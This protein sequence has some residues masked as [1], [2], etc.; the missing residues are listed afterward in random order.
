MSVSNLHWVTLPIGV[1]LSAC[2][3]DAGVL[4][5]PEEPPS[6]PAA[7]AV[8]TGDNQEGKAG[9]H[10]GEPFVIRVTDTHGD[11]VG[12]VGVTWSVTSGDGDFSAPGGWSPR[13][14]TITN[15]DGMAQVFFR[16]KVLGTNTAAARIEG[17]QG[18]PV[19]FTTHATAL[20][21]YAGYWYGI[22]FGPP[23][24]TVP[25]GTT[26]EWVNPYDFSPHT[27]TSGS[28]PPGGTSFD[29]GQ[30]NPGERFQFVPDAA[31]TWEYFCEVH[32]AEQEFGT[33]T[34]Q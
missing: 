28:M 5:P 1:A 24:V 9:E 2:S 22:G 23:D 20:L 21:I 15:A 30:L 4:Q 13:T 33:I 3:D 34:A 18:S 19:T 26:I 29:S 27:V 12:R 10:L 25:V 8:V 32:G 17:L 16:P 31:G 14:V 6:T 11:G 7:I